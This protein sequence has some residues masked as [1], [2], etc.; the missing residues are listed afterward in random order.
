MTRIGTTITILVL[1]GGLAN[2]LFAADDFITK[3]QAGENYCHLKFPA[4]SE[5]TLFT[6]RPAPKSLATGDVVDYYGSCDETATSKDE[7]AAQRR[8]ELRDLRE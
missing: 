5:R 8:D 7:I 6:N 4:I 2:D 3:E 1:V